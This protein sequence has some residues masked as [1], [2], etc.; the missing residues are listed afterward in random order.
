MDEIYHKDTIFHIEMKCDHITK[1]IFLRWKFA[2]WTDKMFMVENLY[3]C[4][5]QYV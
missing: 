2:L 1:T 3:T 4:N 5:E